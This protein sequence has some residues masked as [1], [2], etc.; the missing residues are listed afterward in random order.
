MEVAETMPSEQ[1]VSCGMT[2]PG[3]SAAVDQL[4]LSD[5]A[6]MPGVKASPAVTASAVE[7]ILEG[8]HLSHKLNKERSAGKL[9]YRR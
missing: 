8:L 7:F 5:P 3:M 9:R 2:L 1:Y 6:A 4:H